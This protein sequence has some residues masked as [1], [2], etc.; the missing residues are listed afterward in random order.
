[1]PPERFPPDDPREWLSRARSNLIQALLERP[2]VYLEDLCFQAQQAVEK[3][4]KALLPRIRE[5]VQLSDYAVEARYPGVGEPVTWQEY[6][7]AVV[8]AGEAVSWVE[9]NL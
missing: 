3:A 2:D 5:V 8:L 6:H 4:L 9:E 7:D 1:M